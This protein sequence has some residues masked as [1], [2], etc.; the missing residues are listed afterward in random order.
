MLRGSRASC[1]RTHAQLFTSPAPS[2]GVGGVF[3]ALVRHLIG[4]TGVWTPRDC[5]PSRLHSAD[6][7][8]PAIAAH[9]ARPRG[10]RSTLVRTRDRAAMWSPDHGSSAPADSSREPDAIAATSALGTRTATTAVRRTRQ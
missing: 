10:R 8:V 4:G 1:H 9:Q 7:A 2:R 5:H 3:H 6:M